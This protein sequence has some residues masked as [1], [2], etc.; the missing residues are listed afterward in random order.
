MA[1]LIPVDHD[2]FGDAPTRDGRPYVRVG[3][4]AQPQNPYAERIGGIE[5]AGSGGYQAVGPE[6][7]RGKALGKYQVMPE[8]VGPW[9][10]EILG[11]E[12]TPQEFMSNPQ[13]QDQIFNGKFG[14]YVEKYGPE[15]AA[16]AWFAGEKGMNNP[17]ARDVLGTSVEDY[18][19]KFSGVAS[20]QAQQPQAQQPKLVPVD[21]DPFAPQEAQREPEGPPRAP[22]GMMQSAVRGINQGM[23]LNFGDELAGLRSAAG[24]PNLGGGIPGMLQAGVGAAR[25]GAEYLTG[26]SGASDEYT[27]RVE[28]ERE[29]NQQAQQQ[30]PASY[31]AG[32]VAGSVAL[33]AGGLLNAAT[34]P[35]RIGRGIGVGAGFGAASG[36]GEGES[37]ADRGGRAAIGAGIGGA[38]GGAAVPVVDAISAV[39]GPAVGMVANTVRGWRNPE[40][41]AARRVVTA[42]RRDA[43]AGD[44]G[45]GAQEFQTA[46][47]AGV[48]VSNVD[49]GGETTRAL[50]RSAANTSPEGR[51][52]LQRM[53]DDRFESQGPR[54]AQFVRDVVG[55][56]ADAPT[57]REGLKDLARKIRAPLYKQAYE[58]GSEGVWNAEIQRL[59]SSDAV[60]SAMQTALKKVSD[61]NV[62]SGYGAMNPRITFTPDGR[63]QFNRRPNGMPAFPD[64]QFW[65]MTRREL[66]DAATDAGRHTS[67]GRRLDQLAKQLNAALDK[68]VPSYGKA[69]GTAARLFDVDNA[70]EAGEEFV[71]RG[72]VSEVRS[73]VANMSK[74]ERTLFA[75]GFTSALIEK[76]NKVGD[77]RSI[78]NS[79]GNSTDARQRLNIALGP[80]AAQELTAMLRVESVMDRMR[81]ALGNSTTARQLM[82]AGLAGGLT[83]GY[84]GDPTTAMSAAGAYAAIRYGGRMAGQRIDQNVAR[85]VAELLASDDPAVLRQGVQ[86][87][88]R[89]PGINRALRAFDDGV[90]KVGGVQTEK[91]FISLQP[92]SAPRA[93]GD[94][95]KVSGPRR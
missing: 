15:G 88:A 43:D 72:S 11:R 53:T 64:L 9:S 95:P 85:R 56:P 34:M 21:H 4:D 79:I 65:D 5:S 20:A 82:E 33:P 10:R 12:V 50:A 6:T 51:G 62:V 60:T 3:G 86:L 59:V 37:A 57:T 13:L 49:I 24:G 70:L 30:N 81:G 25:M 36:A 69:R 41:E 42:L 44:L 78:L 29:R 32:N 19:R 61:E 55:L 52:V 71:T 39:A 18:A 47:Q 38:I 14:Q 83:L 77:R 93:E 45:L 26:G 7:G 92:V 28:I 2:P 35:A 48:P 16:K 80:Q 67:Q 27:R 1:Q 46:R 63:I 40:G 31:L 84:S 58:D 73:A 75:E 74:V 90:A 66:S 22:V 89:N 87:V 76:I 91:G 54:V 8:N 68:A 17:N 23:N 94:D